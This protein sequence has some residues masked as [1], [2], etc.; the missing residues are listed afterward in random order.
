M[1]P[2]QHWASCQEQN[3]GA[4]AVSR[5]KGYHGVVREFSW[6]MAGP[7]FS[8]HLSHCFMLLNG[9][10]FGFLYPWRNAVC[11][12][13]P[14]PVPEESCLPLAFLSRTVYVISV[15]PSGSVNVI[16]YRGP[17]PGDTM[18]AENTSG[19]LYCCTPYAQHILVVPLR[20]SLIMISFPFSKHKLGWPHWVESQR[21][22]LNKKLASC[23]GTVW[24]VR[25]SPQVRNGG[26]VGLQ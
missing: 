20:A 11:L 24:D 14:K 18:R 4:V 26:W 22:Q 17:Q 1:N 16:W 21:C 2:G 6:T 9:D 7:Y 23:S 13:S 12:L 19:R 10:G 5:M 15:S 3:S 8:F 25:F